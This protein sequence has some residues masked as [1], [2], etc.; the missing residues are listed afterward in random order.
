[1]FYEDCG[2]TYAAV[3]KTRMING[4]RFTTWQRDI[5]SANCLEV[6]V[7]TT[8]Y[9]GGD[10]GHGGRT[11]LR[12]KDDGGTDMRVITKNDDVEYT[13]EFTLEL[14]GDTELATFIEALKWAVSI[15]EI[16]ATE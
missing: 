13:E 9:K 11:F 8:G 10:T 7:G 4:V 2:E 14:G 3:K 16:K 15:L 1:M 5:T 12:I 6:E